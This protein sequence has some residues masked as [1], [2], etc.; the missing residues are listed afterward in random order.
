M[1]T[2]VSITTTSTSIL[3]L[4]VRKPVLYSIYMGALCGVGSSFLAFV[5]PFSISVGF[6]YGVFDNLRVKLFGAS[7]SRYIEEGNLKRANVS[8]LQTFLVLNRS[9]MV[10]AFVLPLSRAFKIYSDLRSAYVQAVESAPAL[11]DQRVQKVKK[12][13]EQWAREGK[14]QRIVTARPGWKRISNKQ[15]AYKENCFKIT[16]D[17]MNDI[18]SINTD[19][20]Y[21][22]VEPMVNMGQLIPAL[23][24][25]GW[26]LPVVPELEE[27]TVGGMIAGTGV[28]SS[29]HHSGLFNEFCI[30]LEVLLSDGGVVKCSRKERPDIFE[31]F[32]WSYGTLGLLMRARLRIIPS[33]PYVRIEFHP[34]QSEAKFLD[35]WRKESQKG[36]KYAAS[37]DDVQ[38]EESKAGDSHCCRFVEGLL[39]A[40]HSG[41]VTLGDFANSVGSDGKLYRH[42]RWYQ[43]YFYHHAE[44]NMKLAAETGKPIVEYWPVRD[45]YYRHSR[46]VFWEMENIV[47]LG[48]SA[49][50]RWV[51]GWMLPPSVSF[52]K[53][54]T[55][56]SLQ[57][58]Y[59]TKH[60]IQDMLVPASTMEKSLAVFRKHFEMY[61]LWVCPMYLRPGR[62]IVH[63]PGDKAE[64]FVDLGAY[65]V[66]GAVKRGED[67]DLVQHVR[68]VEEYVTSAKG[69][70]MLYADS[71]MSRK[72]FAKMFDRGL[73][74]E[75]RTR[76]GA[77]GAFPDI[78][79]KIVE[80]KRLQMLKER[81]G[82]EFVK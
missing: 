78:Y 63:A 3:P 68:E 52:L 29:S 70:E 38:L 11:H 14:K 77:V 34:F 7:Q 79:D 33:A 5:F 26:T 17:S 23:L 25:K 45:Y 57:K 67:Y 50:F 81:F 2:L 49:L 16:V 74:D 1:D 76:L 21:V 22:D 10:L 59:D 75:L 53:I 30:E 8:T 41:V 19:E 24:K 72:E 18:L 48:D 64:L 82:E 27:L 42:G 62:G 47:P 39:F 13:L 71:Y 55:P 44:E 65:G 61:P 69:F 9:P 4:V 37:F 12:Q 6:M 73:Y 80:P 40:E 32:F 51:F 60:V 31:G 15:S 58:F 28:E 54:T 46:S 35:F 20:R 36:V 43:K 66:P 56:A